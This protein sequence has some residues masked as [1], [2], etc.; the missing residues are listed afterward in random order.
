MKHYLYAIGA[1]L[2][3]ASLPV[4]TGSGLDS[5]S[6]E[7]LM[8]YS[9][10]SAAI[11]LYGASSL[12]NKTF[13][14]RFPEIKITLLGIWGIFLYHYVYYLA[15]DRAS[16]TEGAVLAT[17][18]SF[19]IVVF[20]SILF[21]R[22]INLPILLTALAGM[23]GI[24][25]V[26]TAGKGLSFSSEYLPGYLLALLCGLIWSS[27]TV[28]LGQ[29]KQ[30]KDNMTEFT[31]IAA[32]L[33]A[34][35]FLFTLPHPMPSLKALA[36][37]VY[38]GA[39]PLGLSFVLWN[40]ALQGGN[41]VIIGYLSYMTTPLAVLLVALVRSERVHHQVVLGMTVIIAASVLGNLSL[42]RRTLQKCN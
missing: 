36:S 15:M 16:L 29:M 21:F 3:W 14:I 4:A 11:F 7:E 17:T 30:K 23:G 41:M 25:L 9:F 32:F 35:L 42:K 40:R 18:W 39:V 22:K 19:W 2:C 38:L 8:F 1:I 13:K 28:T 37:A 27:F 6:T 20:S 5:L 34:A 24:T 26:M 12:K 10:T 31:I 33:S